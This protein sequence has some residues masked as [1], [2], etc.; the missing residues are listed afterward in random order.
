MKV[1][2]TVLTTTSYSSTSARRQSKKPMA[3]CL[4]AASGRKTSQR[5]V[6]E[7]LRPCF[8]G[9]PLSTRGHSSQLRAERGLQAPWVKLLQLIHSLSRWISALVVWRLAVSL[10]YISPRDPRVPQ[11]GTE[12]LRKRIARS[13]NRTLRQLPSAVLGTSCNPEMLEGMGEGVHWFQ[14]NSICRVFTV[15]MDTE[16]P[17]YTD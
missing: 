7:G 4:E 16:R 15:A 8:S 2:L 1:G 9:V 11:P 12:I 14:T 6:Q 13:L 10:V 5:W 3:A 17:L